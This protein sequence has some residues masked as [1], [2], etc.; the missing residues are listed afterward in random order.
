MASYKRTIKIDNIKG[1][2]E[3]QPSENMFNINL[4]KSFL[5]ILTIVLKKISLIFG[6]M[7]DTS[8]IEK[9]LKKI[10]IHSYK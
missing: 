9:Q 6:L 5:P 3:I 1:V 8:Y 10:Y 4:S 2:F 7:D